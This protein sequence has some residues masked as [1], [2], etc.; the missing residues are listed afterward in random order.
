MTVGLW[1]GLLAVAA[2]MLA[3]QPALAPIRTV[4][5]GTQSEVSEP[6]NVVVRTE[7]EWTRLWHAHAPNREPP[8]VDFSREMVVGVFLGT[9]TTAGY[10]V[11]IVKMLG[12]VVQYRVSTPP[13]DAITAQVLTMPYHLVA[14][15]RRPG[16]VQFLLLLGG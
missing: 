14:V 1:A 9:K 16:D 5:K 10:D 13:R 15:P 12:N 7:D 11:Q 3:G 2:P 4:D 8:A 6:K